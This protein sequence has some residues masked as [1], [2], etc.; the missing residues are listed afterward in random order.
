MSFKKRPWRYMVLD[1]AHHIKNFETKRWQTLLGFNARR[2]LL[3]T[4]TP[5]QNSLMELWS[6][7]HFLMPH[8]FQSHQQFKVCTLISAHAYGHQ[9]WFGN[10]VAEMVE[11]LK[12]A[13]A[14]QDRKDKERVKRLHS[15]CSLLK[16]GACS[17][18]RA[19]ATPVY[20]SSSQEE[21]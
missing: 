16:G 7:M 20:P 17:P 13:N 21:R 6:L 1:E 3:L 11:G 8:I 5:L 9:E 10:P 4:G 15:V 14:E 18:S 12:T 2:R 19:D